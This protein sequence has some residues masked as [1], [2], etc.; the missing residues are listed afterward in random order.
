MFVLIT[1]L[2]L[3]LLFALLDN[4]NNYDDD[5][6]DVFPPSSIPGVGADLSGASDPVTRAPCPPGHGSSPSLSQCNSAQLEEGRAAAPHQVNMKHKQAAGS[7]R[8]THLG[9][10]CLVLR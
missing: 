5:D 7:A 4:R 6:D 1:I 8:Q 10:F 3:V 2:S 9:C